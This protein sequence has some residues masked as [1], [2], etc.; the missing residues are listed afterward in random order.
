MTRSWLPSAWLEEEEP[1]EEVSW[2]LEDDEEDEPLEEADEEEL[3]SLELLVFEEEEAVPP[4]AV[5]ATRERHRVAN[6]LTLLIFIDGPPG[7]K[8]C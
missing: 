5:R 1:L 2:L 8:Y 3:L 7:N 6:G 4:Q